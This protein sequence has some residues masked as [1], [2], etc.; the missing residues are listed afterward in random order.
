M[1]RPDSLE[2][3]SRRR[4]SRD[5]ATS[6]SQ[7]SGCRLGQSVRKAGAVGLAGR[8]RATNLGCAPV[9]GS[10]SPG[11][12]SDIRVMTT[13]GQRSGC[14]PTT[15]PAPCPRCGWMFCGHC[16]EHIG[17]S[18]DE[19]VGHAGGRDAL[20]DR[21]R[22]GAGDDR[23][24]GHG[25]WWRGEWKEEFW[26]GPCEVKIESKRGEFKR[27]IKCKDGVGARWHEEG[28][29]EFRDG[30][31]T[32]KSRP[33]ATST[34]RRSSVIDDEARPGA[35]AV[36]RGSPSGGVFGGPQEEAIQ[37][38]RGP[39]DLPGAMDLQYRVADRRSGCC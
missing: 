10:S 22:D 17:K 34:R 36:R 5:S 6:G 2:S 24:G 20:R 38:R 1:P 25:R 12:F 9:S 29:R 35:T 39:S 21:L 28:K 15:R 4:A 37:V 8:A 33:S 32:V 11:A 27:E 18:G 13:R 23:T 31:C 30:P 26:N 7:G 14:G 19:D 16:C 3:P